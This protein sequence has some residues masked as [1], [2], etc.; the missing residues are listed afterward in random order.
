MISYD[1]AG[2]TALV[3][4][5]ASG[6]GLSTAVMLGRNGATVAVN[7]LA[8]D[9]RGAD[10]VAKL[11]A[12]GL[13]VIAAPG[14]VGDAADCARMVAKA[15]D[16]LG[17]LDLLVSNA[18]TPGTKRKIEP[19][20]LDLITEELFNT[21]LQ[22]NLLGVFR[23]AKAAAPA[24][25]AAR[26]AIVNTA[27]IAGLGRAGSSMAYSATKA[28]VV[29]LT[30]N[31]ARGLAPDVRVNAVAPGAVDSTW[32][33]EWTDQQRHASIEN[34]LLKR[35]CTTDDIAEVILFLGFGAA[36]VTGQTIVIDGGLTL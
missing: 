24:L 8:D 27:S 26:G 12:D 29:S 31:L 22:V 2:K 1:L 15:S 14:N 9:P 28:G 18:G 7:F 4:G 21:L 3:T 11:K 36:M 13:K 25:K 35:R 33:V 5:G 20:E 30:Q 34:A 16:D 17:R 6:I 32:M 23:C 10:T 19:R